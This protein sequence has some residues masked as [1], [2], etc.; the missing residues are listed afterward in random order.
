MLSA[1]K[2]GAQF[3][4]ACRSFHGKPINESGAAG[5]IESRRR[6]PEA[7]ENFNKAERTF[8]ESTRGEQAIREGTKVRPDE[9]AE[10]AEAEDAARSRSRGDDSTCL[11]GI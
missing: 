2:W 7:A 10:L 6:Q 1:P 8:V 11:D 3:I 5:V 9:E 4:S